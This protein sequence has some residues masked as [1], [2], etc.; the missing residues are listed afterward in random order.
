MLERVANYLGRA[1]II[2]RTP[3]AWAERIHLEL[4]I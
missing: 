1:M 2:L 3:L 4:T